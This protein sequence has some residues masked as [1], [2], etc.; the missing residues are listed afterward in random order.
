M[1]SL[2]VSLLILVA[3]VEDNH[4]L[5]VTITDL[6]S[7]TGSVYI[8]L[9]DGPDLW[10]EDAPYGDKALVESDRS[11]TLEIPNLESGTYAISFYHDA[12]DSGKME[13]N[14]VGYPKEVFGFS[15]GAK[16]VFKAPPYTDA[17]FELTE[18][19]SLTLRPQ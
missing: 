11:A 5:T 10:L 12:N 3:Q 9:Y 15:S 6:P 16:A 14:L 18:S 13:Y 1:I 4:T 7:A 8:G 17:T 19:M 2:I